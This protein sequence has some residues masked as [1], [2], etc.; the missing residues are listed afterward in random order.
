MVPCRSSLLDITPLGEV[1]SE[2]EQLR[3]LAIG[4]MVRSR[5]AKFQLCLSLFFPLTALVSQGSLTA[6]KLTAV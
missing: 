2:N 1:K 4:M 3:L 5:P 6:L